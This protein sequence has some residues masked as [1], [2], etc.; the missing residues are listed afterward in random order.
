M[1]ADLR[2]HAR[3][4]ALAAVSRS[5]AEFVADDATTARMVDD[6]GPLPDVGTARSALESARAVDGPRGLRLAK[7]RLLAAIAAR[8]A[9]G[10]AGIPEVTR[11]LADVADACLRVALD[12]A[13]PPPG[14]AV[15][16]MGKLGG[17]ELN[18]YSDIDVMFVT[19]GDVKLATK[20]ATA[21]LAELGDYSPEGRAYEMD[22]NLRP[23][24]RDGPLVR[25]L[26]GYLEYYRRWA[27]S[28]EYQALIKA[29]HSAGDEPTG[30]SL[31]ADTRALVFPEE[32]TGER[33]ANIR[34]MKERVEAHAGRAGRRTVAPDASDVKLGPG[35]IRD[36]EFSVQL[37][38]LVHGGADDAV[39]GSNTLAALD[40]L[41]HGGYIAEDDGAALSDAY[42]WL[43]TVEHRLQLWQE[44]RVRHVPAED[45]Q[46]ARLA[47]SLGFQN[48]PEESAAARFAEAH[49]AALVDVRKRFEKVFYRPM[50]ESLAEASGTRLPPEAL[51]ERLRV[52]NFRDVERA[53]R[54]LSEL[55]GGTSRRAK[56]FRVITPPLLR[57]LASTPQ[58][59]AGLLAFLR[60]GESLESRSDVLGALRD[61][62]PGLEFLASVLGSGRLLGEVLSHVPDELATIAR[63][64]AEA[65]LKDRDRLLREAD[66]SLEWRDASKRLD[67]LR[68]FKRREM[69]GVGLADVAGEAD[70]RAVGQGLADL[71]DACLHAA[72]DDADSLA[73][74]GMGKL[75]G[76]ELSYASDVD[77]MFVSTGDPHQAEKK[78]ENLIRAIGEVTP[79][80]QAFRIDAALRPEGKSGSLARSLESFGEYYEHR[81]RA[82]ERLALL[83]ARVAAGNDDLGARYMDL[84]RNLAYP[85]VLES[86]ELA[87]IRHLKARME[88]ER[89][90][91]GS[92]ARRNFK[93]GPGGLSDIE[94]AVQ[95]LQRK[96]GRR[97]HSMQ[98]TGTVEALEA[99]AQEGVLGEDDARLLRDAYL[100]LGRLRNR[101]F[102]IAARPGDSLPVKPEELEA[103]GI[104]MGYE[105]QPRQ[106]LEEHYLRVTRRARKVAEPLIYG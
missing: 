21:V 74:I 39:R 12:A 68:R 11:A 101:L 73:I 94:F 83:K 50:I 1:D 81:A 38:Q 13:E 32:V 45:S 53:V 86:A 70:A 37:L 58:P 18:Y 75:G 91:R 105:D 69:L 40:A 92:D 3:A 71:A 97:L 96:H 44:R 59:D 99:A 78:A 10:E 9:A 20:A 80:G 63:P 27:K 24:G 85:D 98:V 29:R 43:R 33:I 23:E 15:I 87:E 52:L 8:D 76:R 47:H 93:L 102:F 55:V 84:I 41:V 88:R 95:L 77:I 103:L 62:P 31:I 28:W 4:Q 42:K 35:G 79:E 6:D 22:T 14:L 56:L 57:F 17:R 34:K 46:K 36:I 49:K 51:R 30:A 104:A 90:P 72:L 100:W 48:T 106:E 89:I 61:N 16:S 54:T 82:W 25:S 2:K 7:R 60:L 66:A 26:E 19:S 64:R 67:G 5:L 65:P